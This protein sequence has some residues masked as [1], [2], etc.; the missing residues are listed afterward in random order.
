MGMMSV[1]K[2]I[3]GDFGLN[4]LATGIQI[5]CMQLILY[6]CIASVCTSEQY[7][8]FLTV[9]GIINS[10]AMMLGNT[11]N[12]LRLI[13]NEEYHSADEQGDFL[14]ILAGVV[15][16]DVLFGVAAFFY[17]GLDLL[18][19]VLGICVVVLFTAREY[20]SVAFRLKIN[21]FK[22]LCLNLCISL[23]YVVGAF[24]LKFCSPS[25][26]YW[27]VP[28]LV[29]ELLAMAYLIFNTDLLREPFSVT[30]LFKQTLYKYANLV[31][32]GIISCL[33]MYFDR[34]FLLPLLGGEAVAFYFAATVVS[35]AVSLVAGPVSGVLLSYYSQVGYRMS[36]NAFWKINGTITVVCL[37]AYVVSVF[38]SDWVVG[39]FYPSLYEGARN[40]FLIGNV[41][42][43]LGV[44]GS[45]ARP[46]V[47]RFVSLNRLSILNTLFLLVTCGVC[48]YG[49]HQA[50][51]TG[52]IYASIFMSVVR[53][54]GMWWLGHYALK[55]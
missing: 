16:F 18:L 17:F 13:T 40:L 1:K 52:F 26:Q 34:N 38:I 7:G 55:E 20:F 23:G 10:V 4:I 41:V 27:I 29:A 53:V 28:F 8:Y 54:L 48:Y 12:N 5:I 50:A 15:L 33:L 22:V 44:V 14:I 6:P 36:R 30:G 3:F 42:P 37:V 24:W 46:A 45:M 39:T 2:K 9:I 43:V 25:L 47:L 35:K 11:L 19:L 31:F 49:I 21:Y 51:L 32:W